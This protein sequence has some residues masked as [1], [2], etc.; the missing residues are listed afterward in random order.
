VKVLKSVQGKLAAKAQALAGPA[1]EEV[2]KLEKERNALLAQGKIPEGRYKILNRKTGKC[3][4]V[5]GNSKDD[6]HKLHAYSYG[7][8]SN[9]QW[10]IVP[11][12]NGYYVLVGIDSGKAISVPMLR[13]PATPTPAPNAAKPSS[14]TPTPK[15]KPITDDN[16]QI[17]QANVNKEPTQKW[18]IEKVEKE[19]NIFTITSMEDG[20]VLAVGGDGD[21]APIIQVKPKQGAQEQQWKIE[22]L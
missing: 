20:K 19:T 6:G 18:K 3:I 16:S 10:R 17:E 4:D 5:E 1:D 15:P 7:N 8:H 12:D 13:T 2:K 14:P 21:K 11:Q 9:Q 22:G